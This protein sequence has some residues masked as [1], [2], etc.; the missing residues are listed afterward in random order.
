MTKHNIWVDKY[1]PKTLDDIIGH[2]QIIQNLKMLT[3][4]PNI[5]NI[6]I[7][8]ISGIGKTTSILCFLNE[9]IN[10]SIQQPYNFNEYVLELNAS[11]DLR[12]ID[13]IKK[14]IKSFIQKKNKFNFVLLDE[15]D[16]MITQTQYVLR[17]LMDIYIN[18]SRFILICNNLHNIIESI[19]SRCI[20]IKYPELNNDEI[21]FGLT[22]IIKFENIKITDNALNTIIKCSNGDYRKSINN[23]QTVYTNF[24]NILID[25]QK[26]YFMLDMPHSKTILDILLNCIHTTNFNL[27]ID[28]VT[29]LF[30][31][32]G[33]T[34]TDLITVMLSVC[35]NMDIDNNLKMKF[36]EQISY[37][38]I[39]L[40]EGLNTINQITGLIAKLYI[41]AQKFNNQNTSLSYN[42]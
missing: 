21:K 17:S 13:I 22:K 30:K 25:E 1:K 5:P 39:K 38:H 2:Q 24:Q 15:F 35:K 19:K 26:V 36:I 18:N 11:D 16:N 28:N 3:N 14:K 9:L 7:T 4:N 10:K 41:I 33:Y 27:T 34:L 40:I 8:G 32:K 6:I 42:I 23:L 12:K 20:I 37:T 29:I 31:F